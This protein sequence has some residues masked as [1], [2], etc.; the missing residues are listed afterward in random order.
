[1]TTTPETE[2]DAAYRMIQV[3]LERLCREEA[4]AQLAYARTL[5]KR[6][7]KGFQ[8]RYSAT[9]ETLIEM[10]RNPEMTRVRVLAFL[11]APETYAYDADYRVQVAG[12]NRPP[13]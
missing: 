7:Q 1:M 12:L 6:A 8:L 11:H 13:R 2:Y 4:T 10:S 3:H 5:P 9:V